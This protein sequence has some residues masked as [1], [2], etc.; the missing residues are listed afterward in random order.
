MRIERL[1]LRR[2]ATHV[3]S[4][5]FGWRRS[6]IAGSLVAFEIHAARADQT[7]LNP[8]DQ[9]LLFITQGIQTVQQASGL[10]AGSSVFF[11]QRDS[12]PH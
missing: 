6:R 5:F 11:S 1:D 4:S 8:V 7:G 10:A 3:G 9:F 2:S 12:L